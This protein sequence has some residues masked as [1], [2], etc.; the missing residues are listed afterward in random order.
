MHTYPENS[1][2]LCVHTAMVEIWRCVHRGAH[3]LQLAEGAIF[4]ILGLSGIRF[5]FG[6]WLV[7][8]CSICCRRLS[9]VWRGNRLTVHPNTCG[10]GVELILAVVDQIIICVLWC[11]L[12]WCAWYHCVLG[13]RCHLNCRMFGWCF[14]CYMGICF[15]I[16]LLSPNAQ[17]FRISCILNFQGKRNNKQYAR[18]CPPPHPKFYDM[19]RRGQ[20]ALSRKSILQSLAEIHIN[21]WHCTIKSHIN[22]LLNR[23][24]F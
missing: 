17:H 2:V 7:T 16:E 1:G 20:D 13:F 6:S 9:G 4:F 15:E 11:A 12:H 3:L 5:W 18:S 23:W 24:I 14:I 10:L 22:Y 21:D 8:R 19:L